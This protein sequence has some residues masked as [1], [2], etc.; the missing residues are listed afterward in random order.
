MISVL[1]C[2]GW[3]ESSCDDGPGVRSVLFL[4]GCSKNCEG[5]HNFNIREHGKG[6]M[7]PVDDLVEFI[8]TKCCNKKITIS[9]GEPLE[10]K[11]GLLLLL[12]K[13]KALGYNIC[14]YTGWEIEQVPK[15]IC[16]VANYIKA[17]G[18]V[19][20][21]QDPGI[22]YVGSANQHLFIVGNGKI[23]ELNLRV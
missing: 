9:G 12:G 1:E 21:L 7:I 18:F 16:S 3:Q 22:Q 5:C 11:E 20:E 13:L 19:R 23:E 2:A 4:Q 8:E 15:E 14:L 10:Q 17:G 6:I